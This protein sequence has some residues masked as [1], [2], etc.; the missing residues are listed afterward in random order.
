[1]RG[2][3]RVSTAASEQH[4]V[5]KYVDLLPIIIRI[6][7]ACVLAA[8]LARH[9]LKKKSLDKSGAAAAFFVGL[10]SF[11][12]SYR[13]GMILILFYLSSSR[14]TKLK[15]DV[16]R[17]LEED[18]KESGQRNYLQVLTN[19]VLATATAILYYYYCGEDSH[20]D[21]RGSMKEN[22]KFSNDCILWCMYVAHYACAN[23][24]TW[25]SEVG[26][27]AKPS[28]RLV[29]TMFSREVPAG[30]NGGMSMLG[31]IASAL[32]GAFIGLSYYLLGLL[33]NFQYVPKVG[34]V[35]SVVKGRDQWPMIVIG[36]LFGVLGSLIDS[37]LGATLQATYFHK[38]KKCI[39][40]NVSTSHQGIS[41]DSKDMNIELICGI[42]LLSNEAVNFIS[43]AIS[44]SFS[45]VLSPYIFSA[46]L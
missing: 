9:G 43:I 37:I 41:A 10:A 30:T 5:M 13:M 31:T 8:L 17:K 32:G 46:C 40:K 16:K 2:R 21:F 29:T 25:A 35:Y 3:I 11:S 1:M 28:P 7:I 14:L 26:I 19:S 45:V 44:M 34:F 24:D 39:V 18:Y 6:L 38:D 23:G 42:D 27:L 33:Q 22:G 12:V 36:L 20:A 15:E 4:L